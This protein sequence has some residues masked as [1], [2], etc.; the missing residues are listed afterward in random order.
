MK[1]VLKSFFEDFKERW[2]MAIL[3]AILGVGIALLW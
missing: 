3:G 2:P 1:E